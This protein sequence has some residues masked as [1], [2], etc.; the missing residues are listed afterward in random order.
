MLIYR[1]GVFCYVFH[2][3][4]L[5]ESWYRGDVIFPNDEIVEIE[6]GLYIAYR[7]YWIWL[8]RTKCDA[9]FSLWNLKCTHLTVE[10]V[11]HLVFQMVLALVFF[12][13]TCGRSCRSKICYAAI[14]QPHCPLAAVH[15]SGQQYSRTSPGYWLAAGYAPVIPTEVN[16][17]VWG[18][19][20]PT[21]KTCC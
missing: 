17:L 15:L 9:R 10:M 14:G 7:A 4:E 12:L 1:S 2:P 21:Q 20:T 18:P 11:D 3:L 5:H 6:L 19:Q 13:N 8:W 16:A